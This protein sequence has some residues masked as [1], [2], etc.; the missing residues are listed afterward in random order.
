MNVSNIT[1][2]CSGWRL[3]LSPGDQIRIFGEV[4]TISE[5]EYLLNGVVGIVATDGDQF[6]VYLNEIK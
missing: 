2:K 4:V 5:I 6:A 1:E 3:Q